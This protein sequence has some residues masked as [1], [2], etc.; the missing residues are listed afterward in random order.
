MKRISKDDIRT[1]IVV[2][3]VC[4]I[5]VTLVLILNIK[6]NTD[7]MKEVTE[8][9]TFFSVVNHINN[10]ITNISNGQNKKVYDLLDK[11]YKEKNNI[12]ENNIF[13]IIEIYEEN[14]SVKVTKM[15]YVKVKNG[16]LY[17]A[18]ANLIQNLLD[19]TKIIKKDYEIVVIT[20]FDNKTVSL[21]PV[22]NNYEKIINNIK[23]INI[24]KNNNNKVEGTKL[25][26]K[27]QICVLYLSDYIDKIANDFD[28]AYNVLNKDMKE[29]Y[30]TKD[31]Y[32]KFI[33]DNENKIT[34]SADKCKMEIIEDKR[35]Y[36]VIDNKDN[37]YRFT[38]NFVMN[39][40][41]EIYL[42]EKE[43]SSFE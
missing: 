6:S 2:L 16:Y 26:T 18:K 21:Y 9:N 39:Y 27:E 5:C 22:N 24:E 29:I 12:T 15:E 40:E 30:N 23:K 33:N 38:E 13:D 31:S 3:S 7:K 36:T 17:Y 35:V 1:L 8:H 11:E 43:I 28:S 14:I 19:N 20:D 34:L 41:V 10:Y 25:I 32:R 42:K 37:M 4:I